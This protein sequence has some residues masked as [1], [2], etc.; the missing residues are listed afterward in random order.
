MFVPSP[1]PT[2]Q[3]SNSTLA[4]EEELVNS[5]L[6]SDSEAAAQTSSARGHCADSLSLLLLLFIRRQLRLN[7]AGPNS[8]SCLLPTLPSALLLSSVRLLRRCRSASR[9]PS[10][11]FPE[12][13][14]TTLDPDRPGGANFLDQCSHKAEGVRPSEYEGDLLPQPLRRL[15]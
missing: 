5:E 1:L 3:L 7:R 2:A 10:L 11:L 12:R 4:C 15:E 8:S 14:L 13:S 6:A 9:A